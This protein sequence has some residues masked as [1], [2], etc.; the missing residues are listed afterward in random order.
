MLDPGRLT[1][2]AIHSEAGDVEVRLTAAGNWQLA[3]RPTAEREW[4]LACSGDLSAGAEVPGAAS[5]PEP[6]RIGPLLLDTRSRRVFVGDREVR[7]RALEYGLL[8]TLASDP[9]RVFTKQ[10]LM[11][12]VWGYDATRSTRT[13][14]SHASRLR[15]L[16]RRAGAV[17]LVHCCH[18]VGYKL[19][20][21]L[22]D[23][24]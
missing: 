18:G 7:I 6:L 16:L 8:A 21:G 17:G 23:P 10:E 14:E 2:A 1:R 24:A 5:D 15:V 20:D 4:R 9:E 3:V 19:S 11:R 12:G 22:A 13:L